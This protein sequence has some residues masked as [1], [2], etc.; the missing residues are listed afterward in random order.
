MPPDSS[1]SN[2]SRDQKED[3]R[4]VSERYRS[5]AILAQGELLGLGTTVRRTQFTDEAH[6][7]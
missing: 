3:L 4:E 5:F 6:K 1:R 7:V 2:I